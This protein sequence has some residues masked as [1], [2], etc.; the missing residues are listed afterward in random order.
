MLPKTN[1]NNINNFALGG[2]GFVKVRGHGRRK[3]RYYKNGNPYV[4]ISGKKKRLS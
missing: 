1:L 2:K 3:I 4:I